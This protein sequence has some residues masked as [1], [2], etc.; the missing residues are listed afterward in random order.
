LY[1]FGQ[2]QILRLQ[3]FQT[4]P[5]SNLFWQNINGRVG[6]LC[7]GAGPNHWWIR[8]VYREPRFC[9][10][11]RR[12]LIAAANRLSAGG[13]FAV[14]EQLNAIQLVGAGLILISVILQVAQLASNGEPQAQCRQFRG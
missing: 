4:S 3:L 1:S 6:D 11:G 13:L 12:N 8:I 7:S 5:I 2:L 9:R 10:L 14:G